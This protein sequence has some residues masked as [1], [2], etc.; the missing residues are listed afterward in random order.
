MIERVE[1]QLPRDVAEYINYLFGKDKLTDEE[2]EVL[3]RLKAIN[4][5]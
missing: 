2:A 3:N 5:L 4:N 1:E